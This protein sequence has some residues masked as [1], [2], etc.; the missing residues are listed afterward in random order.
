M[1]NKVDLL[2]PEVRRSLLAQN[3]GQ[4]GRSAAEP[5]ALSAL[6]GQGTD[7]LL[8]LL[9]ILLGQTETLIRLTL[10]PLD[11]RFGR[12]GLCEWQ[13]GG[14]QG[15]REIHSPADRRRRHEAG[16]IQGPV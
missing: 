8:R 3:R 14:A 2:E 4:V 7:D 16:T 9:D 1:L 15:Q 13:G 6:T 5:I 12:V 10:D 11:R